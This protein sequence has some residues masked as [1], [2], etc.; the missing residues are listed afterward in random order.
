MLFGGK[1]NNVLTGGA[2]N[3]NFIIESNPGGCDTITDF[4]VGADKL[5]LSGF[6]SMLLNSI[7]IAQSGLDCVISFNN[8][9][10]ILLKNV[11]VSTFGSKLL[12]NNN[13]CVV[14][15]GVQAREVI[16]AKAWGFGSEGSE[17]LDVSAMNSGV[18]YWAGDGN[19]I[20]IGTNYDDILYGGAGSDYVDGGK[21]NDTIYLEGDNLQNVIYYNGGA[22]YVNAQV[23][24]GEG[25]DRFVLSQNTRG[26]EFLDNVIRD[27]SVAQGDVIDLTQISGATDFSQLNIMNLTVNDMHFAVVSVKGDPLSRCISLMNI[28]SADLSAAN[29]IFKPG[30]SQEQA[31]IKGSTGNDKLVGDA[32]GNII[33]GSLGADYMEGRTGDDTYYV[34]NSGDQVI[35]QANG[36][37]DTVIASIS[38]TL[39]DNF[40]QLKL[41]GTDNLSGTGNAQDNRLFGNSGNNALDGGLGADMM[42][43]GDG[44]DTYVVDNGNDRIFEA[45]NQG[46]DTVVAS[47]SY[48]LGTNIENLTL[49]GTDAINAT[50]NEL[51]NILTG[52][53]GDN[54]LDGQTGADTMQG[55][56]GNDIYF[57]DNAGD[58]V[59]ENINEGNDTVY[60]SVDYALTANVENLILG[61]GAKNATGNDL[62]NQ[63]IGNSQD[64]IL[65]GGK[66][67]DYLIGG[68]G[69]D[70]Y[71]FNVGDGQDYISESNNAGEDKILV[72][73]G[74]AKT[75]LEFC[76]TDSDDLVIKRKDSTDSITVQKY[77]TNTAI[78][79][80]MFADGTSIDNNYVND[81]IGTKNIMRGGTGDNEFEVFSASDVVIEV[82]NSGTDAVYSM[83]SRTL[84]ANV[85]N[86]FLDT[87][88]GSINGYGNELNNKLTG[89]ANANTLS[90][91]GGN[92]WIDARAGDDTLIGGRGDDYLEGGQ[93]SD[94]YIFNRGDGK[95]TIDQYGGDN[96]STDRVVFGSG[97]AA[98]DM[99]FT[100][101][102]TDHTLLI[103]LMGTTDSV[104]IREWNTADA[105]CMDRIETA[106][107]KML[108]KQQVDTMLAAM[109]QLQAEKGMSWSDLIANRP[110]DVQNVVNQ[111]WVDKKQN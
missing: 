107:G 11:N 4:T 92:D 41:S 15:E 37:Y 71:V 38:Y 17:L 63:L 82:A 110:I 95:D 16:E 54:K 61:N 68:T 79:Q 42:F 58:N 88:G 62:D 108:Y 21:G 31:N 84:E 98:T 77:F 19:N 33:D 3:D 86:L 78:E 52:N 99:I 20:L 2:N 96:S 12:Y 25:A 55:G 56:K 65:T 90:G 74:I 27:F 87:D 1:G 14:S 7:S 70:T 48:T 47:M 49:S 34:D 67:R 36:G 5:V 101:N 100:A 46:N 105:Q 18:N 93:G 24:G 64:N 23:I 57:V 59:V 81:N 76:K 66:G 109:T 13:V 32:G 72:G 8:G 73:S 9:Q 83:I 30:N 45:D 53:D 43:G 28:N 80:I 22:N 40:E 60:S 29:F 39:G 91:Q 50:G 75:D 106:D 26:E 111:F 89:N 51:N 69:N 102:A 44:D 10:S 103:K 35:E 6:N 104:Q 94:T 97:I 85:E